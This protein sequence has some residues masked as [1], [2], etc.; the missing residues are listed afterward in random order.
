M[1]QHE[2]NAFKFR[3]AKLQAVKKDIVGTKMV[4]IHSEAI[5]QDVE[6]PANL[7][8]TGTDP[9]GKKIHRLLTGDE[10][11]NMVLAR[12][13]EWKEAPLPENCLHPAQLASQ[14][15]LAAL[16]ELVAELKN[17]TKPKKD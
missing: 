15:Q 5:N 3:N 10:V 9:D 2:L 17:I 4:K 13:K 8:K 7:V 6:V 1:E 12:E 11:M 16:K 14:Q